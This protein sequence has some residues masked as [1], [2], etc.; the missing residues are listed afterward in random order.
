MKKT[1]ALLLTLV[2]VFALFSVS[3]HADGKCTARER[4]AKLFDAGSFVEMDALKQNGNVVAGCGTVN[5]Q[6]VY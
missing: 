5:G 2:M 4:A 1:I 3:A 6:A